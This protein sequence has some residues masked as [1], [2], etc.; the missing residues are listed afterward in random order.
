M[1]LGWKNNMT[2]ISCIRVVCLYEDLAIYENPH[3]GLEVA[4]GEATK[5]KIRHGILMI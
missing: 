2:C 3:Y 1:F 5:D 4:C